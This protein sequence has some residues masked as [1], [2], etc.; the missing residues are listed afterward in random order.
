MVMNLDKRQKMLVGVFVGVLL[1][2]QGSGVLWGIFFGPIDSRNQSIAALDA[3]LKEK[4]NA[5]H[6]LELTER[7]TRIWQQRSLP[8]NPV[9]AS[10]LYHH[11]ILDL[12]SSHK[13]ERLTV[14]PK[15]IG[16]SSTSAVFTRIPISVTAECKMD[17]LCKF[18]YDFYRTD[19]MHKVTHL[20][21]ESL[22]SRTNPTLKISLELEGLSLASAKPRNTLFA[23]KQDKAVSDAMAKK[24]LDTY[25]PLIAQN[26][27]VRGYNGPPKPADPPAPPTAPF[28]SAPFTKLVA[29]IETDGQWEAWLYDVSSNQ[30]KKIYIGK[31]FEVAGIKGQVLDINRHSV[32]MKVKDKDW[33][34]EVGDH[35]KQMVELKSEGTTTPPNTT[36]PVT[37]T[38]ETAPKATLTSPMTTGPSPPKAI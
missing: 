35:L 22:D 4:G 18:L 2:W 7:Q 25:D 31:D 38:P 6:K 14:T 30:Q 5:R 37:A 9:I 23:D 13:L 16:T 24:S 3:R 12:A 32:T 20:G 1:L 27:F 26:R 10:T 15:R 36:A 8:P 33:T 34:L 29:T 17:Q 21:L 11:W 28:D 19:L